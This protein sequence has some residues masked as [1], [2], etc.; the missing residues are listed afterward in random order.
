MLGSKVPFAAALGSEK[1][2]L[3]HVRWQKREVHQLRHPRPRDAEHRG[4]LRVVAQ[5]AGVD[6]PLDVVRQGEE[7]GRLRYYGRPREWID[8]YV[9]LARK[10][11]KNPSEV[12]VIDCGFSVVGKPP[13][14]DL[15]VEIKPLGQP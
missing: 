10:D 7:R 2:L 11:G 13:E 9:D 14:W 12:R 1:Q 6:E 5:L 15:Y 8:I 4:R 3:L